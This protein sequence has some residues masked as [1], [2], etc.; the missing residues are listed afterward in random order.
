MLE[1]REPGGSSDPSRAEWL[2]RYQR[3]RERSRELFDLITDEAYYSRPIALRHPIVFYEGHLPGFS[4][5]TLVKKALG[6]QG[7]DEGLENVFARGI[8][9]HESTSANRQAAGHESRWPA[10]DTVRAFA[11]QADR[12]VVDALLNADLDQPGHPLL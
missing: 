8:D 11:D 10:R 6:R 3:T 7:I 1:S 2:A 12:L 5:N 4:L 9:P